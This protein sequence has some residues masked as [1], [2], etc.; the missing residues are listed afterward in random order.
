MLHSSNIGFEPPEIDKPATPIAEMSHPL[1]YGVDKLTIETP[2]F[3]PFAIWQ[4]T[5]C[6]AQPWFAFMHASD[7]P[8]KTHCVNTGVVF[9]PVTS[10]P[11]WPLLE[12][13]QLLNCNET[14]SC[15]DAPQT[16][17]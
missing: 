5:N 15:I 11:I 12:N 4:L 10:R 16:A 2:I 6:G 13:S 3:G 14:L 17:F 1:K 8:E 7:E 9:S